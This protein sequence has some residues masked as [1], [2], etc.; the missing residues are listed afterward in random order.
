MYSGE[1]QLQAVVFDVEHVQG[2]ERLRFQNSDEAWQWMMQILHSGC[3]EK[4]EAV[5]PEDEKWNAIEHS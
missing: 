2:G 4:A 3:E 1:N 5:E